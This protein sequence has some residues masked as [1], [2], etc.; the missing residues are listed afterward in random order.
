[1]RYYL[2]FI[3]LLTLS[4]GIFSQNEL[5]VPPGATAIVK[6]D[7]QEIK[8]AMPVEDIE[9]Y[10]FVQE[11]LQKMLRKREEKVAL[12]DLNINH[13]KPLLITYGRQKAFSYAAVSVNISDKKAFL[14]S[15]LVRNDITKDLQN[16]S[17]S[18]SR[19]HLALFREDTYTQFDIDWNYPFFRQKTDS[20]FEANGWLRN[21]ERMEKEMQRMQSTEKAEEEHSQQQK[22]EHPSYSDV[23]DSIKNVYREKS[24][25]N[26]H[27]R[28]KSGK[29]PSI[30]KDARHQFED[31][32]AHI[33][34]I[35]QPDN[36]STI[37]PRLF[38]REPQL[39]KYLPILENFAAETWQTGYMNFTE[40]GM[41]I[42]W[43]THSDVE[44][45][46]VIGAA[47]KRKLN[48]KL[49]QYIPE[50]S[51]GYMIYNV[52]LFGGYEQ[53]RDT[54]LPKVEAS[55]EKEMILASAIWSTINEMINTSSV[56]DVFGADMMMTYNGMKEIELTKTTY[57]YNKETMEKNKETETYREKRPMFTWGIASDKA[58]LIE[59][60]LKALYAYNPDKMDQ[61]NGYYTLYKVLPPKMPLYIAVR[62]DILLLS[63][64][65]DLMSN[66]LDGYDQPISW[67]KRYKARRAK[68]L[69][70]QMDFTK[71]PS[72][73]SE[74]APRN[75]QKSMFESLEGK[76]GE[77][78]ME[79][80]D[81]SSDALHFKAQFTSEKAYKNGAYFMMEYFESMT[82][83]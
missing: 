43:F 35:Y 74:M 54:Y 16:E 67:K 10:T 57:S 1:M 80:E 42:D 7:L 70:A 52:D 64:D 44:I 23:L 77:L 46:E 2:L 20:I 37:E 68:L 83:R 81:V 27:E 56:A 9:N 79:V 18:S 39:K 59:K 62:D 5:Q 73:L 38:R 78:L 40:E 69:Y 6:F 13:D 14:Q 28:M 82:K 45:M 61:E 11:L 48:R 8:K 50:K 75:R 36:I 34:F 71:L 60:Y 25:Q 49:L 12:S 26:F 22:N 33:K 30:D 3:S 31:K 24:I 41:N 19:R 29:G 63:N 53:L 66:H 58:Y 72:E 15:E 32:N 76:T 51:Q 55:D 21:R 65:Q 17:Y 4:T 47:E